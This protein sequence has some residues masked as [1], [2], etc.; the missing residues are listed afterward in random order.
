[1]N[2]LTT[3]YDYQVS[4]LGNLLIYSFHFSFRLFFKEHFLD[5][6]MQATPGTISEKAFPPG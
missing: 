5:N 1:M 6:V 3:V 4:L 2:I